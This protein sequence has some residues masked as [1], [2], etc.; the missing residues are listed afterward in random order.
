MYKVI[1]NGIDYTD[2]ILAM[3]SSTSFANNTII[4]NV[5]STQFILTL[6]NS[7][8]TFNSILE[9]EFIIFQNDKQIG[10]FKVYEKPELMTNELEITLYDNMVLANIKYN[11]SL[12]IPCTIQEQLEEMEQI[13]GLDINVAKIEEKVLNRGVSWYDNTLSIREFLGYIGELASCN[14]FAT[15]TGGLTF[16][17]L[18]KDK[19]FDLA[20]SNGVEKFV[21]I[22]DFNL[23]RVVYDN[24]VGTILESGNEKGSSYYLTTSN[25]YI[26]DTSQVEAIANNIKGLSITTMKEL[27]APYIEGLNV[28]DIVRYYDNEDEYNFMITSLDIDYYNAEYDIMNCDGKLETQA[29]ENVTNR[30]NDSLKIRRVEAK[31][32]QAEG[33]IELLGKELD[34]A[35]SKIGSL[36]VSIEQ[37]NSQVSNAIERVYKFES[38]SDNIFVNCFQNLTKDCTEKEKKTKNDMT[39]DINK[40]FMRNKDICISCNVYVEKGVIGELNNRIGVRFYVGYAD[41]TRK[42]YFAYWHLGQYELQY[43]LQS[44]VVDVDKRVW[45]HF[46]L[47]DKE[48]TSVSNLEMII[49]LNCQYAI[50]ANPKV[51][52]GMQPT[53]INYAIDYVRDNISTIEENFTQINQ[54]L[55]SLT[56]SAVSQEKE[57][58]TIK[59]NITDVTTRLESAEIKLT[60]SNIVLA[61][62]EQIG[63]ND[64]LKTTKFTLDKNG[65]HFYGGGIDITNNS[66]TKVLYADSSGN[67]VINNLTANNG[68]F[69]GNITGSTVKGSVIEGSAYKYTNSDGSNVKISEYGMQLF[70][71]NGKG[72]MGFKLPQGFVLGFSPIE[73]GTSESEAEWFGIFG[74]EP[75]NF[76]ADA[77]SSTPQLKFSVLG[78]ETWGIN[79]WKSDISLKKNIKDSTVNGLELINS[80]KHKTFDWKCNDENQQCGYIA[81]QLKDIKDDFAIGIKQPDDSYLYQVNETTLIPIITKAIQELSVKIDDL[82][83]KINGGSF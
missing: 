64:S 26:E 12:A 21:T 5:S 11:S 77:L 1:S 59:G 61:V 3:S 79:C 41:G 22:E 39:L 10:V 72:Y 38:G 20:E 32:N 63:A 82:E 48:V 67:L 15:P 81:Q 31:V 6:D 37:I 52:F 35:N 36:E 13:L 29:V 46:K 74:Q 65:G 60:P 42:E 55:D 56:M 71:G 45:K 54:T 17:K 16:K 73:Y 2:Y 47:E 14:C 49:D 8:K 50:V 9:Q 44:S 24:G 80:I 19:A 18:S 27:K 23:T 7:L 68:T 40:E 66:G 75:N 53:D 58:T 78:M 4:G 43:L 70:G 62:N 33:S 57:I 34:G 28:G 76:T 25:L 69:S 51:E 30:V 83:S